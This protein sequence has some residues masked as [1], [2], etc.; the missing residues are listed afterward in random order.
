MIGEKFNAKAV[1][2]MDKHPKATKL[3]TD[4]KKYL[5]RLTITYNIFYPFT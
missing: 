4:H 2:F 5:L 1:D 3:F